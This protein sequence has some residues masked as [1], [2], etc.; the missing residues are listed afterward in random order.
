MATLQVR[1]DDSLK[2]KADSLFSSL[3]LD[4]STAIRIFLSSS[5][6]NNGIPF[7]VGHSNKY[8]LEQA[9]Y[10]SR[11]H[12]NLNGPFKNAKEAVESMLGE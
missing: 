9:V 7:Y 6:E 4:T 8:S 12:V 10:D 2:S 5:V 11:N 3:G 1:V